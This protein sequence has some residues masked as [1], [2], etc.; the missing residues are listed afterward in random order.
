MESLI[1]HTETTITQTPLSGLTFRL[2]ST[3]DHHA[4]QKTASVGYLLYNLLLPAHT[5]LS[6]YT[7]ASRSQ[8]LLL[9]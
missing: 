4:S 8:H 2:L 3:K 6:L 7:A 5:Y 9:A 1:T